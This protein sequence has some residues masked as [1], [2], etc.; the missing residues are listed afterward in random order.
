[1]GIEEAE[2]NLAVLLGERVQ[3]VTSIEMGELSK[4]FSFKSKEGAFVVHF[5]QESE[6][7]EK[8]RYIYGAYGE[9][10]PIPRIVK[11]GEMDGL[12]YTISHK[13]QGTPM[14]LLAV[15]EQEQL[16]DEIAQHV[17]AIKRVPIEKE[18]GFGT[19]SP[20][21]E[22]EVHTWL[23]ALAA[24]FREDQ[25]GFHK[26]WTALYEHSFLDKG[27]FEEG[28]T[29]MMTLA[30]C[31]PDRPSLVHGDFH[32][33]NML[34]EGQKVTGIVDWE[35]AMYGD[36]MFDVACLHFWAPHLGFPEKIR[37]VYYEQEGDIPYFEERL[38][39]HMLFKAI[40]GLR[41]YAKK[42]D[43]PSYD[44]MTQRVTNILKQM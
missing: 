17:L 16:V 8:A 43:K 26:N 11:A 40:D 5:R 4:V 28:F 6:S 20:T 34:A 2:R 10:L 35:M 29:A 44:Y 30:R 13:V 7:L 39:C 37:E 31:S 36:F 38:Y 12:F 14:S 24:F 22:T 33:G 42:D 3:D 25:E 27:L 1:M 15:L 19:I 18:K 21:G 32:L 23:E 41:F 9:Q